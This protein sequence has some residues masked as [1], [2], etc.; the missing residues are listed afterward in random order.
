MLCP[1]GNMSKTV[2]YILGL[3]FILSVTA[4]SGVTV[5]NVDF[6]LPKAE[7]TLADSDES[8]VYSAE[9]VYSYALKKAGIKF[10]EITVCTNKTKSGSISIS[11]V[12][13]VTSEDR[14]KITSALGDIVGAV[15]VEIVYE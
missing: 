4:A 3:V 8:L 1:E 12:R 13:I 7:Y 5:K 2:T 9:Y 15:E 6:Q 11:K 14:E 10:S